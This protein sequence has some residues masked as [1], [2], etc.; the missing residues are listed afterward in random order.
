LPTEP[1]ADAMDQHFDPYPL[2]IW[3]PNNDPQNIQ[4]SNCKFKLLQVGAFAK[5]GKTWCWIAV[6]HKI[7]SQ[8][9]TKAWWLPTNNKTFQVLLSC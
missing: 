3:L 7:Q 4:A 5:G 1:E 2:T 8:K 9:N 6:P